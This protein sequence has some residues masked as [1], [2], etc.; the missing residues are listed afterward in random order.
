[1]KWQHEGASS[2]HGESKREYSYAYPSTRHILFSP[3]Y[4]IPEHFKHDKE[5][6]QERKRERERERENTAIQPDKRSEVRT[7]GIIRN[8]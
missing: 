2:V 7:N 5:L 8:K 4:N 1:M 6:H 3:H